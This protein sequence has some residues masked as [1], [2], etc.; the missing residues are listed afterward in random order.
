MN[1]TQHI[2]TRCPVY[3]HPSAC[4]SPAAVEAIQRKTGLLV[5]I[6]TGIAMASARGPED[7]REA[8]QGL[9]AQAQL[10]D[11][12]EAQSRERDDDADEQEAREHRG[13]GGEHEEGPLVEIHE[14]A[15]NLLYVLILL[16]LAGVVF[17]TRRSGRQIVVAMLPGH[18]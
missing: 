16:H 14:V 8:R 10:V 13:E 12:D 1:L 3:L 5:I 6:G 11:R 9:A 15:A 18:R 4:T 7:A 2:P 17:E